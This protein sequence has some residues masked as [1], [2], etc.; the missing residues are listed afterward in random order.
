MGNNKSI[1][2]SINDTLNQSIIDVMTENSTNCSAT[3]SNVQTINISNIKAGPGCILNLSGVKNTLDS[4]I[5]LS[6][7]SANT[8]ST[9]LNT[10]LINKFTSAAQA[11]QS[12]LQVGISNEV[13]SNAINQVVNAI[14]ENIN[15]QNIVSSLA[16]QSTNQLI[17]VNNV[18]LSCPSCCKD[19][20]CTNNSSCT[21]SWNDFENSAA[22]TLVSN[23]TS[24]NTNL[25]TVINSVSNTLSSSSSSTQTGVSFDFLLLIPIIIAIVIIGLVLFGGSM[26]GKVLEKIIPIAMIVSVVLSVL[27]GIKKEYVYMGI[28]I[29]IFVLLGGF[30]FLA[31]RKSKIQNTP[32]PTPLKKQFKLLS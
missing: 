24:Q 22:L 18:T 16:S 27:Y 1:A 8:S 3:T 12:G 20:N 6:C 23:L 21:I 2:N 14:K 19:G 4:K 32:F 25:Q 26:V 31:I 7:V 9:N 10:E 15:V 11:A 13:K 5:N 30:E 17:N 29:F 28:L